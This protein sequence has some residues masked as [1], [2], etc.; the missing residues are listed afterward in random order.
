[1]LQNSLQSGSSIVAHSNCI[2]IISNTIVVTN[3]TNITM[4]TITILTIA[5]ITVIIIVII[6]V[7]SSV[8]NAKK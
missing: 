1:M 5:T 3:I 7:P 6:I 4:T 2:T 8:I